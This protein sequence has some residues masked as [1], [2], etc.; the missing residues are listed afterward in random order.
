MHYIYLFE[1][2]A[3]EERDLRMEQIDELTLEMA[4]GLIRLSTLH[5]IN[6]LRN[7]V[8]NCSSEGCA[9]MICCAVG[10]TCLSQLAASHILFARIAGP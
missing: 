2:K 1:K 10:S 9:G 8:E 6:P 4:P 7:A 5:R 3:I